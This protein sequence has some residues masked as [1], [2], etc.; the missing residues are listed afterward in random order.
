MSCG[1]GAMVLVFILVKY[2]VSDSNA[3][4]NN[5]VAEVRLLESQQVRLQQTLDQLRNT[6]QTENEKIKKL[7][8]KIVQ[9]KQGLSKKESNLKNK[10]GELTALKN[11]IATRPIAHKDDLIEDDRGGEENYL[12][13]LKVE[14]RRIVVLIDSSASMT[15]EKLLNIIRRKNSSTQNKKQGPKWLRTKKIVRWLL[16]RTPKVSQLSVLAFNDSIHSLGKSK[17]VTVNTDGILKDFYEKLDSIVPTGATNLHKGLQAVSRLNA[18]D[19]YIITDGLPTTGESNYAHLNPFSGCSS[20]LGNSKSISGECRVK[21]FRQTVKDASLADVKV[22]IILLPIEGDP[23]AVNEYWSW[24]ASTG[25]LVISPA[26]TW[27]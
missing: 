24:A 7:K 23:S 9:I 2:D 13:G 19:L 26:V 6:S 4:A 17:W 27:P 12:I 21:L 3:E 1:L 22:N 14:G 15:D 8:E 11:S 20:L 16:A 5:L 10:K 18:T 25:G